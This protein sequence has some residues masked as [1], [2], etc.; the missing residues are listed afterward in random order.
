MKQKN[1]E[2]KVSLYPAKRDI[3]C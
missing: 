2:K 3:N 1:L